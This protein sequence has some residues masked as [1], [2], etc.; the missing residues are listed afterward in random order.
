[1]E[2]RNPV[3]SHVAARSQSRGYVMAD[4]VASIDGAIRKTFIVLTIMVVAAAW[5]WANLETVAPALVP[6]LVIGAVICLATAFIPTISPVSAPVY[7][8]VEGIV[9]GVL[10]AAFEAEYPGIVQQAV[11]LT[12]AVAYALMLI[13]SRGVIRVSGAFRTMVVA[14]TLALAA[15]YLLDII[16]TSIFG[17]QL[18]PLHDAGPVGIFFSLA[19]VAIVSFN[20]VLDFDFIDKMVERGAPRYMEWYAAFGILVTLIWMY[21]ELLRLLAK[22]RSRNS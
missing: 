13:Y 21:F 9:L 3:F 19:A 16:L 5:S 10:S 14:A 8:V 12:A 7:A 18:L 22:L 4:D 20:L 11:V 2:S 1:M 15:V 17:K 6:S